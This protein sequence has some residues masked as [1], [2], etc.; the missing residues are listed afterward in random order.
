MAA[1]KLNYITLVTPIGDLAYMYL[2]RPD[3]KYGNY[4]ATVVLDPANNEEHKA[5][6]EEWR[7]KSDELFARLKATLPE[8]K[9]KNYRHREFPYEQEDKET[10]DVTGKFLIKAVTKHGP[11]T[12]VDCGDPDNK[13]GPKEIP[14]ATVG[15]LWS[16]SKG[17]LLLK[18]KETINSNRET[19]GYT[20][21]LNKVQIVEPKFA[22]GGGEFGAV[23]GGFQSN[24]D[25]SASAPPDE[26]G[27]PNSV[28]F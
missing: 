5:F 26:D 4:S 9:A 14:L 11:V 20:V 10:G 8:K 25:A 7:K 13:V 21:Y 22:G 2:A 1:D 23:A 24:E 19:I 3:Q 17:R 18:M 15:K 27:D 16:G 6:V 12:V 28:P